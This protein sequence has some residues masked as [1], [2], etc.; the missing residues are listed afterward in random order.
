[1]NKILA[2]ARKE[3]AVYFRLPMAYIIL[4]VTTVTFNAFFFLIIDQNAEASLRDVFKVME[5]MFVFLVPLLT[6]KAFAEEKATGTMEFLMT[7]PLKIRHIVVGKYLGVLGFFTLMVG[8][9]G[10]YYGIIEFFGTPDRLA[11]LVG[12][13]G[14]WLEGAFFLA[15]GLL[16]SAWTR[17]QIVAAICSYLVLFGLYFCSAAVPYLDG[18]LREI[19]RYLSASTHAENLA[20][21]LLSSRDA[22]YYLT[23]IVWCLLGAGV[24]VVTEK[25]PRHAGRVGLIL[26]L[27][28]A[29][30]YGNLR[31]EA[32][33]DLTKNRQHTLH[34]RTRHVL[35]A[36]PRPVKLVAFYPGVP[37][38]YLEDLLKEYERQSSGKITAEI[39]DPLVRL[40]YAA[41]FGSVINAKEHKLIAQSGPLREDVDFTDAPLSEE[42][43]TNAVL[44]VTRKKPVVYFLTGHREYRMDDEGAQGLSIF[45]KLL[46]DNYMEVRPLMLGARPSIPKDC[47]V[48][49]IAG[50]RE[51]LTDKETETIRSYLREGGDALFLIE[52]TV[53]TT[54]DKPL[55]KDQKTKNPSLNA[56]LRDW[57]LRVAS[58]IVVD[59]ASHAS[60]DVGSPATRNYQAYK[61]IMRNL[62]Y[63]FYVRPRSIAFLP[64]RRP[65]VKVA[66]MV[67][68]ASN[69]KSSW[70]ETNRTLT[71]RYDKGEDRPGP[72]PIAALA[73]EARGEGKPSDTR[74]MVFTDAD[75]LSNAY[76]GQ[77]SNA[78][79]GLA[80]VQWVSDLDYE[81][82]LNPKAIRVERM[83][84][85]SRQKKA[86]LVILVVL[87]FIFLVLSVVM[88]KRA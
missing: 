15:V 28:A 81:A 16:A 71:V 58:D 7:S 74:L 49:V 33:L 17:H 76:V 34:A 72:V 13:G 64:T 32:R 60:G 21:G 83:N 10:V 31:Y 11:T 69:E 53:V 22:I 41:Q 23:G 14:V 63:T 27:A 80:A 54:P 67:L 18:P 61:K 4:L 1:M 38:K 8:I 86:V 19:A 84:L 35:E 78:A 36:L 12:Y 43:I 45:V 51:H 50:P 29:T 55:T 48:L 3:L 65:T 25:T 39:I 40:D 9:T 26:V 59:L 62:D 56:I 30:A 46:K 79:M 42:R 44:K 20:V 88:A 52:H 37:P 66:P 70:G 82:F 5:F 47:D 75:F 77:Y 87:P 24:G 73:W 6:M 2:V 85:T 57:G 68:T